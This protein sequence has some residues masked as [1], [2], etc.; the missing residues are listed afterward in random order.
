MPYNIFLDLGPMLPVAG[1][2][3]PIKAA[4]HS[5]IIFTMDTVNFG[6]L[7]MLSFDS[8]AIID[9]IDAC[10]NQDRISRTVGVTP[11]KEKPFL[12]YTVLDHSP[13]KGLPGTC[14]RALLEKNNMFPAV[15]AYGSPIM[16]KKSGVC[17]GLQAGNVQ[18]AVSGDVRI[19]A[20]APKIIVGG[21]GGP[22]I[23]IDPFSN[24]PIHKMVIASVVEIKAQ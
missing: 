4:D 23:K 24:L 17:V 15:S 16:D 1:S 7:T 9:I 20:S 18:V 19:P 13:M 10:R 2:I 22:T 5:G 12:A 8:I 14:A 6:C 3:S 21:F 11:I